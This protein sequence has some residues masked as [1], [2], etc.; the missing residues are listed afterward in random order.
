MLSYLIEHSRIDLA[1]VISD[2]S[3]YMDVTSIEAYKE[4][5]RVIRFLLLTRDTCL[6][7]KPYLDNENWGLVVYSDSD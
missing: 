1:N 7:L 6:K 3:K 5:I 2:L 4:M